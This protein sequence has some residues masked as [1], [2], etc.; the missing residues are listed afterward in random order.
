MKEVWVRQGLLDSV[1]SLGY[2]V[3]DHCMATRAYHC[4]GVLRVGYDTE[5]GT[6]NPPL[7]TLKMWLMI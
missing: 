3:M 2:L 4:L 7:N 6:W 5:F 1:G